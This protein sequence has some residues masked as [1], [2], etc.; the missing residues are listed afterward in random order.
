MA[1][2]SPWNLPPERKIMSYAAQTGKSSPPP[3]RELQPLP[4]LLSFL[5]PGLGQIYQGRVGKGVLFL[6]CIYAL[7]FYGMYLGSGAVQ[8]GKA[9][10]NLYCFWQ[11]LPRRRRQ[12]RVRLLQTPAAAGQ[13]TCTIGRSTS[14]SS[15]SA[16][17]PGRRLVA[18][19]HLRQEPGAA[20]PRLGHFELHAFR[21]RV[22]RRPHGRGDKLVELPAGS[23]PSSPASSISW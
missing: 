19:L 18:V 16:S 9:G 7:F 15:G 1:V 23:I 2:G 5:V 22:K 21:R 17:S 6:V 8:A 4:G 13:T 11:R 20:G 3:P 14:A 10:Q 12:A